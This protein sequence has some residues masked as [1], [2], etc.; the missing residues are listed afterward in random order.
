MYG[1]NWSFC[2]LSA[3]WF[4]SLTFQKKGRESWGGGA[5]SCSL[6]WNILCVCFFCGENLCGE[7]PTGEREMKFQVSEWLLYSSFAFLLYILFPHYVYRTICYFNILF[8]F[9]AL[10]DA[11]HSAQEKFWQPIDDMRSNPLHLPVTNFLPHR[12]IK[13]CLFLKEANL[14]ENVWSH[15]LDQKRHSNSVTNRS[16]K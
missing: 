14:Y 15:F 12:K 4:I 13:A 7:W 3:P 11:V 8:A 10:K 6:Q 16:W 9:F 2:F 5:M 1:R